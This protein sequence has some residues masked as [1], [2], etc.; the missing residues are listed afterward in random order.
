MYKTI[1]LAYDGSQ[2][3][4][5][6]LLDSRDIVQW[7]QALLWLVAVRPA[8]SSYIGM[9]AGLYLPELD[10]ADTRKFENVLAD[11]QLRLEQAGCQARGQLLVGDSV[12]QIADFARQVSADLIVVGH[13]HRG[14]WAERWWR[15]SVSGA[16]I[17]HAPCSV[18]CV[19]SP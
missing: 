13:K 8:A 14:S 18:L 16:L 17:E 12:T 7:S 11:G 9:E 4:Q 2:E 19:I 3:G 1:I 5:R 6:A 15:G 10:A